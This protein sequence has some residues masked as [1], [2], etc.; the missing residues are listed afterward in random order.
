MWT[1][2]KF[3][4]FSEEEDSLWCSF[5]ITVFSYEKKVYDQETHTNISNYHEILNMYTTA[6]STSHDL[7]TKLIV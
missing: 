5:E 3:P 1:I 6:V 2:P 4:S 7:G